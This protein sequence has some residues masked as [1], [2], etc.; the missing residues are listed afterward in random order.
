MEPEDPGARPET[1]P[2]TAPTAPD[3]AP[4]AEAPA[5]PVVAG[6]PPPQ[7]R[8][9]RTGTGVMPAVVAGIVLAAAVIAFIAQN[10]KRVDL[11]WLWIDFRTTP[12]VLALIALFVGVVA[13]VLIGA[14]IRRNRRTRLNER[15]ELARLRAG[16]AST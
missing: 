7:P 10:T 4:P 1:S 3:T 9:E 15:E 12:G 5:E 11:K 8:V 2:P 16:H 14:A 6:A 13:A